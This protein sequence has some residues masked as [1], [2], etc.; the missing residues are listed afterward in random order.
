MKPIR[1]ERGPSFVGIF[2]ATFVDRITAMLDGFRIRRVRIDKVPDK[3]AD[4]EKK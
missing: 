4:Q 1:C 2:V 3:V